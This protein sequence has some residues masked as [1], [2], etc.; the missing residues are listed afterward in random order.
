ME[1]AM[2]NVDGDHS[3]Q[4]THDTKWERL[5]KS[6]LRQFVGD[7]P[8]EDPEEKQETKSKKK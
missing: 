3:S 4:L 2:L 5:R 7:F 6:R 1:K 8:T